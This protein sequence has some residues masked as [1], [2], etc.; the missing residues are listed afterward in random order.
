MELLGGYFVQKLE[1]LLPVNKDKSRC[2]IVSKPI[3]NINAPNI[4]FVFK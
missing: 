3:E 1:K 4:S 2:K